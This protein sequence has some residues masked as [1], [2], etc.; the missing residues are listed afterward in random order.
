M[1]HSPA[2]TAV[3]AALTVASFLVAPLSRAAPEPLSKPAAEG[4]V[5]AIDTGDLV[6]DI[7]SAAGI[8][9]GQ[10]VELWRPMRLRHPVTGK[11]L[12]DRFKIGSV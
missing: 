5:A 11:V 6:L 1:P 12:V 2:R 10:V 3:F 4:T 8:R 9:P 7:G